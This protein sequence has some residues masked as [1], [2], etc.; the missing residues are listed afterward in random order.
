MFLSL[1]NT[2][3]PTSLLHTGLKVDGI[4]NNVNDGHK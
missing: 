3:F 4:S 1:K 2:F